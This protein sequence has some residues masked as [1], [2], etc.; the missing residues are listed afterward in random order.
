MSVRVSIGIWIQARV[1]HPMSSSFILFLRGL[2]KPNT[3]VSQASCPGSSW[4]SCF[5]PLNAV[6]TDT[7]SL[8]PSVWLQTYAVMLSFSQGCRGLKLKSSCM[9]SKCSSLLSHHL[10]PHLGLLILLAPPLKC[11]ECRCMSPGVCVFVCLRCIL[12]HIQGPV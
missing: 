10:A 1:G 7:R 5:L 4:D 3:H 11:W 2:T 8:C 9:H 6:V 12:E